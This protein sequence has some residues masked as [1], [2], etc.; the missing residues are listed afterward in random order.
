MAIVRISKNAL[1]YLR[2]KARDCPN[3]I[4]AYLIGEVKYPDTYIVHGVEHPREYEVQT[5]F[6][7]QPTA[8]EYYRVKQY[9]FESNLRIIGD[10]H[11]HP[12]GEPIMSPPDYEACV[13]DGLQ[14]CG[15][16][17]VGADRR[18]KVIFWLVNSALPCEV[19]YDTFV[20]EEEAA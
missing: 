14:I 6:N 9:A 18:T 1:D 19:S 2:K 12:N 3:E 17:S 11:S 4:Q 20:A 7:V 10:I 5:P 16:V 13:A 15:I 8:D